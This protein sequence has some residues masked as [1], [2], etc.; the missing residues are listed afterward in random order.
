MGKVRAGE[1]KALHQPIFISVI[2]GPVPVIQFEAR[3]LDPRHKA[4]DDS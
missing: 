4:G 2:T 3:L 1:R